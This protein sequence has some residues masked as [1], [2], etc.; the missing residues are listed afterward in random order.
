LSGVQRSRGPSE[1]LGAWVGF[2]ALRET[3]SSLEN[4]AL[5]LG[6]VPLLGAELTQASRID[7][8]KVREDANENCTIR[9]WIRVRGATIYIYIYIYI[10]RNLYICIY[11]YLIINKLLLCFLFVL[12]GG[13]AT[14]I[15]MGLLFVDCFLFRFANRA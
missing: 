2:A 6:W 9:R 4:L 7:L 5:R 3:N 8:G 11:L 15:P 10:H 1:S 13:V 14:C 12:N